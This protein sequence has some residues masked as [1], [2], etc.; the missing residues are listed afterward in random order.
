MEKLIDFIDANTTRIE[1]SCD[2]KGAVDV[3][4][5]KVV[6]SGEGT[7]EEFL[8]LINDNK[9]GAFCAVDP[10][11]GKEHGY[12]ELGAWIG[13]QGR[14]MDFMALTEHFNLA[15]LLTPSKVMGA[16]LDTQVER[17]LLGMGMV[18][19]VAPN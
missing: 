16:N 10:F 6:P 13:D 14:A 1:R 15:N 18:T 7:K 11:D 8:K 3:G 9:N 12:I 4:F 5:F 19:I 17:Q 2:E